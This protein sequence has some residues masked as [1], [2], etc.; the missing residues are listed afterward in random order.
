[1]GYNQF[2]DVSSFNATLNEQMVVSEPQVTV[3]TLYS[4][5]VNSTVVNGFNPFTTMHAY[6]YIQID[7][8]STLEYK[9]ENLKYFGCFKL[10]V[11]EGAYLT[12]T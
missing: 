3:N 11:G 4:V 5:G 10:I 9:M 7:I 12:G 8:H 6:T 2:Q 1:M